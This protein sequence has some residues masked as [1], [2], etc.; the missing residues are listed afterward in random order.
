MKEAFSMGAIRKSLQYWLCGD[1]PSPAERA[2]VQ[3]DRQGVIGAE[4]RRA[5]RIQ[6]IGV[7]ADENVRIG[8][9]IQIGD[10]VVDD[11]IR[12]AVVGT[13]V[14]RVDLILNVG[15]L[16]VALIEIDG[17]VLQVRAADRDGTA[18]V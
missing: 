15:V 11:A 6:K 10:V 14:G 12:N 9:Q 2:V 18:V 13:G 5:I 3:L 17:V 1:P 4:S 16:R 8:L 7:A